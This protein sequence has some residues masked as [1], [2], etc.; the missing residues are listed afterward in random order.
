VNKKV[1]I[2]IKN[3]N[4]ISQTPLLGSIWR[5]QTNQLKPELER[6]MVYPEVDVFAKMF[7]VI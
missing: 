5:S 6:V 2:S 7:I 3:Q 4:F 1:D